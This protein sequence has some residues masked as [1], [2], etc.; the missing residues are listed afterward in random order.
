M[1]TPNQTQDLVF[2]DSNETSS[3]I[4]THDDATIKRVQENVN[5]HPSDPQDD[6]IWVAFEATWPKVNDFSSSH[7]G[8]SLDASISPRSTTLDTMYERRLILTTP[9]VWSPSKRSTDV[10]DENLFSIDVWTENEEFTV[11]SSSKYVTWP[12]LPFQ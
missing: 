3:W 2:V 1:Y 9:T 11:T 7:Q 6:A 5:K 10:F 12:T 4:T 8:Q